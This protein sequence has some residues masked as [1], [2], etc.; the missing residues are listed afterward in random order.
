MQKRWVAILIAVACAV[1]VVLVTRPAVASPADE[2]SGTHFGADNLPQGCVRDMSPSNPANICH[3]MRTGMNGLDSPQVDV[4]VLVPATARAERDMRVMR[5]SIEMWEAGIDYLADQMGLHWLGQGL[6]FHITVDTIDPEDGGE[7]TTYP[8]VDPEIVVVAATNPAGVLG[9]GIDP[10]APDQGPCHGLQNP[11]DIE[12]WESL[13]GFDSHHD[14]RSGTYVEDCGGAGG[15]VCFAVNTVLEPAPEV[16]EFYSLYDTVSH[17]VGHCLTIGHVGDGA[18]GTWGA[19]P[20]N[21]IMAYHSD[22]PGLNK[23]VS[24]LNVEGIAVTMSKYLDVNG[25]E[26]VDSADLLLANDQ[27]GDG[28]NPFQVQHPDDHLYASSTGEPTDCPQ[29]DLGLV[30]GPR[31]EWTPTPVKTSERT[32]TVTSPED[33]ATTTDGIVHV[34]GTVE[35]VSLGGEPVPT[36]P[37]GS[38]DDADDDATTPLTEILDLEVAV[39][40]THL[41]ATIAL[42][43]LWPSTTVT[44]PTSYSLTV[45]GRTFDSFVRYPDE[46]N[47][48]TWDRAVSEYLPDGASSWDTEAKTVSFH[49]PRAYLDEA[50]IEA[51]YYVASSANN[52][53][54]AAP[55][56]DDHAPE[57]GATVPV[58][59]ASARVPSLGPLGAHMGTVTFEHPDGNTFY[60]EDSTL[61]V[62]EFIVDNGAAHRYSLEVA[63]T[64]K[65]ELTLDWTDATG[66]GT[67]LDLTTSGAAT[68]TDGVTFNRPERI[69]LESVKGFLDIKVDPIVVADPVEGTTYTLTAVVTPAEVGP[70]SD[71]DGV[72]DAEDTCPDMA[73]TGADGCPI[74]ASEHVHVSVDGVQAASQDVDTANGPDTFDISV[75]VPTGTHELRIDWE[76]RGRVVA[77]KTVTITR[78]EPTAAPDKPGNGRGHGRGGSQAQLR[79]I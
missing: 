66:G 7:F 29:P 61:G 53:T 8:I 74:V 72:P 27:I 5:Q 11:F 69:V 51:P 59:G 38:Y 73:G 77:T 12:A 35:K 42:A 9:I 65:V 25:D 30:P 58:A 56:A 13:P 21:D 67:D 22:P 31:T 79:L 2:Y 62:P 64:S 68:S 23:C 39:T 70:D 33:G 34:T 28:N 48:V 10:L 60:T 6:D 37:T 47:P 44:S 20:T 40:P 24:T 16:V 14:S 54:L 46:P 15:N 26:K 52:G 4:L 32:L 50:L 75:T 49:I 17:E 55:V 1:P 57:T 3:H 43:D 19:L 18:E 78:T 36:E 76:D 63:R 45:D 71:G 41:D